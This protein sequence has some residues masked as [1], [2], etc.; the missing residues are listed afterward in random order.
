MSEAPRPQRNFTDSRD[1]PVSA[2]MQLPDRNVRP[3]G[4]LKMLR[5]PRALGGAFCGIFVKNR[6][7]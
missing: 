6:R 1:F 2:K 7:R 3:I 4:L 5:R